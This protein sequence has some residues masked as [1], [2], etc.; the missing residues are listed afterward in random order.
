MYATV[1]A[2]TLH[3][4]AKWISRYRVGLDGT[5]DNFKLFFVFSLTRCGYHSRTL[6]PTLDSRKML[7]SA[8]AAL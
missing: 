3:K 1:H 7:A 6:L 4:S 2:K 5:N 8:T